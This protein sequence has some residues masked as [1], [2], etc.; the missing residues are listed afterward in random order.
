MGIF[1]GLGKN[2]SS[3]A[4]SAAQKTKEVAETA[5]INMSINSKES[6][7]KQ[8]YNTIGEM[9]Y[10]KYRGEEL[11]A[12]IAEL[13]TNIDNIKAEIAELKQRII[14]LRKIVI[15]PGCGA[16]N[17]DTAKFCVQCGATLK[18]DEPEPIDITPETAANVCKACNTA[19]AAGARFC[20]QCGGALE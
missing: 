6:D 13:C 1:D 11:P 4:S 20:V 3:A 19:N 15:C 17:G 16:E 7:I 10:A 12:E 8:A 18:V 9:L 2:I 14:V 5:K